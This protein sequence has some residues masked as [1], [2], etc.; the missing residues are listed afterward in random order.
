MT[1][2]QIRDCRWEPSFA[3]RVSAFAKSFGEQAGGQAVSGPRNIGGRHA[4][5]ID[6][7]R[8][9]FSAK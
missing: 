6:S 7:R 2:F 4:N 3:L 9:S 5:S 1:G 8:F